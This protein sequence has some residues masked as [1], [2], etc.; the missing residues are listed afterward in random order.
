MAG[1]TT[2]PRDGVNIRRRMVA[3]HPVHEFSTLFFGVVGIAYKVPLNRTE[4]ID[5]VSDDAQREM[6]LIQIRLHPILKMLAKFCDDRYEPN[7][8]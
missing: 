6:D 4:D 8:A 1:S 5:D 2:V 3:I 7:I